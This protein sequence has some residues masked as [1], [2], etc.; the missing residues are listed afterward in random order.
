MAEARLAVDPIPALQR[1]GYEVD[2]AVKKTQV[3]VSRNGVV[4]FVPHPF[5][6]LRNLRKKLWQTIDALQISFMPFPVS[7]VVSVAAGVSYWVAQSDGSTWQRSGR[8]A[9]LLWT[10][11]SINPISKH[12]PTKFRVSYLAANF[13]TG[14]LFAFTAFQRFVLRQLLS[15]HGWIYERGTKSL[16]TKVWG[17]LLKYVFIRRVVN[18]RMLYQGALPTLPLP[19]L[20]DTVTKYLRTVEPFLSKDEYDDL[21][22]KSEQFLGNEGPYLQ[23]WLRLKWWISANYI[24]DWWLNYVYLKARDS[25]CINS[26]WYGILYAEFMPTNRQ[27]ARAAAMTYN[28]LKCRKQLDNGTFEPQVIGGFVPLCMAQYE[29]CFSTTRIPGRDQDSIVKTEASESRHIVVLH[30]GRMYRVPVYD[31]ATGNVLTPLQIERSLVSLLQSNDETDPREENIPALTAANRTEWA[32]IREDYFLSNPFN[33][34]SLEVIEKAVFVLA[35]DTETPAT[36]AEEGRQYLCG[37]GRNRW[38]DKSFTLCITANG[39]AGVHTEHAWGDAPTLAHVLEWVSTS[40]EVRELYNE[41]GDIKPLKED[42]EK[43][44][45]GTFVVYAPE[46]IRFQISDTLKSKIDQVHKTYVQQIDDFDLAVGRWNT[47][48]KEVCKKAKCSPDAWIQM[49]MQLAYFRDQGRCDQTYESS[50][51]RLFVLGRTETI[52]TV[53]HESVAFVRAMTSESATKQEKQS[54]LRKACEQHQKYS[55]DCMVGAGVDR[56]LFALYVVSVGKH[57]ESPFLRA[58]LGRKWKLSTSQVLT[59]QVPSEFHPK[60]WDQFHTPNGGFG[61]VAD[62]G[63]GVSYCVFGENMF[64]FNV[65]SKKAAPNTNSNVFLQRIFDALKD[66]GEMAA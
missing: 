34:A 42:L 52:R 26:N 5:F 31:Y 16:K 63:Y 10:L 44:K 14:V 18:K 3:H 15:Y 30:K 33:R 8:L 7:L 25:L 9:D 23:N 46:R 57:R 20:K 53:S 43:Q 39:K 35:L 55:H 65:S 21:K 62:D 58:A 54:A 24:S 40:D 4:L 28:L 2:T 48:G 17:F 11:D 56:H 29:Y 27:A 60:D 61:P 32:T 36:L 22:V 41:S 13:T 12:I 50:M 1:A 38:S 59:R 45:D 51:T 47:Y 19:A 49:A 66:M 37:N 6:L 64:Y